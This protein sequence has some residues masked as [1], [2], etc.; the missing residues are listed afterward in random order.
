MR[1]VRWLI[2]IG[3]LILLALALAVPRVDVPQTAFDEADAPI[4]QAT[5]VV[6]LGCRS[7]LG[8]LQ[9]AATSTSGLIGFL[10]SHWVP[11][12][13][14]SQRREGPHSRSLLTLLCTL[15]C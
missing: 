12:L 11:G 9:A 6:V 3:Q 4:N 2:L 5:V 1:R 7:A 8:E 13:D 15:L 14:S 10:P